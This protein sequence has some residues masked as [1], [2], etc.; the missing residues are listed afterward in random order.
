MKHFEINIIIQCH[1][2]P[3]EYLKIKIL[4]KTEIIVF[5]VLEMVKWLDASI[6]RHIFKS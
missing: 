6:L 4:T 1:K 2:F 3:H 5:C